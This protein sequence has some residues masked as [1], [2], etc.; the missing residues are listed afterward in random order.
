MP[1]GI[2]VK[3]PSKFVDPYSEPRK[4]NGVDTKPVSFTGAITILPGAAPVV[5]SIPGLFESTVTFDV[6]LFNAKEYAPELS[7][8][9]KFSVPSSSKTPSP[10]TSWKTLAPTTVPLTNLLAISRRALD[11]LDEEEL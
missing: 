8:K 11:E 3:T 2:L 9:A 1:D 10:S 4:D 6:K 7:V 5:I